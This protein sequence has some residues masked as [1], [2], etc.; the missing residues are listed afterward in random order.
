ME[1]TPPAEKPLQL[2]SVEFFK[3]PQ[4]ELEAKRIAFQETRLPFACRQDPSG[5]PASSARAMRSPA[6]RDDSTSSRN[7]LAY[8]L[9]AGVG[10]AVPRR[11]GWRVLPAA[12]CPRCPVSYPAFAAW[13]RELLQGGE[14]GAA[15]WASGRRRW[16]RRCPCSIFP[17]TGR[18]RRRC[19]LE[20]RDAALLAAG[21]APPASTRKR[22]GEV[23]ALR[24]AAGCLLRPLRA[25]RA[26][27]TCSIGTERRAARARR[28][29]RSS[30]APSRSSCPARGRGGQGASSASNWAGAAPATTLDAFSPTR[31]RPSRRWWRPSG[32]SG[33]QRDAAVLREFLS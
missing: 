6:G 16:G 22:A 23:H 28:A 33:R 29:S 32:R 27:R 24:G 12:R 17:S 9:D 8:V 30:A 15:A 10:R 26:R 18:G 4:R 5:A 13:Q 21:R 31:C 20:G 19:R 14:A 1:L 3:E 25:R 11:A 7:R 2:I